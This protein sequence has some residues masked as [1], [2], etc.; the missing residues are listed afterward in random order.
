MGNI[1]VRGIEYVHRDREQLCNYQPFSLQRPWFRVL[2]P[3]AL[4]VEG[5]RIAR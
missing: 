1:R 4:P 3:A 5:F 2:S